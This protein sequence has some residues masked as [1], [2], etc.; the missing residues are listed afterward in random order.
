MDKN[1]AVIEKERYARADA[2]S[3]AAKAIEAHNK[4]WGLNKD[5]GCEIP[6]R[7]VDEGVL[8]LPYLRVKVMKVYPDAKLPAY[9]T[10]G[11]ACFDIF[12]LNEGVIPSGG[13]CLFGT[14]LGFEVP[15]AWVMKVYSR[16]GHGF[17]HGIRL[18]NGTGIIDSDYR[19]ELMVMLRNDGDTDFAVE[20]G[21]RIAQAMLEPVKQ[22][23]FVE[24][25]E[26]TET[27]RG[28]GGL[29]STGK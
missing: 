24:V 28:A 16:S 18:A 23:I 7:A 21:D 2:D 1:Q 10:E 26:L 14:G 5:G 11:A 20:R 29:G 19:G 22:V 27:A 9:A 12:A 15:E 25:A 6:G 4:A 8:T 13:S 17:K 3:V